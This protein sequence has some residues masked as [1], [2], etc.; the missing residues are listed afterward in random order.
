MNVFKKIALCS[1]LIVVA[2]CGSTAESLPEE[3]LVPELP[4][5]YVTYENAD[6]WRISHPD[7]W[8]VDES[9]YTNSGLVR[10][11]APG[12][13][14]AF[15]AHIGVTKTPTGFAASSVDY[16]DIAESV[17]SA[18]EE[19]GATSV[20]GKKVMTPV[21][22]ALRLDGDLNKEPLILKLTQLQM[23]RDNIAYT[24]N[25]MA[26]TAEFDQFSEDVDLI[27]MTFDPVE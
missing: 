23:Y 6:G 10:L 1:A 25:F 8:T 7:T 27:L 3:V 18:L 12:A 4:E 21:G 5:N 17:T 9:A 20:I 13:S 2:G 15:K 24:L 22:Y 19:T 16:D 26:D 14:T 11:V